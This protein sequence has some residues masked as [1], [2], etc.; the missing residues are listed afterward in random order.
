VTCELRPASSLAVGDLAGL[1]TAAFEGYLAPIRMDESGLRSMV[2]ALDIDLDGSRVAFVE[3]AP[4]GLV[5]LG[6]RGERAWVGGMGVV[7]ER[8]RQGIGLELMNGVL[9]EA[10]GRGVRVVRLEVI[11]RNEPALRLYEGIGFEHERDVEVWSLEAQPDGG[12]E[13]R[14][15]ALDEAHDRIRSLRRER[16][17]WQRDDGTVARLAE[18]DPPPRAFAAGDGATIFRAAGPVV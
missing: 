12:A 18:L 13:V 3:G 10:R 5:L 7:P 2:H 17:P 9:D 4:A 16:E 6:V 14:N 8:R 15:V 1:F 11:D